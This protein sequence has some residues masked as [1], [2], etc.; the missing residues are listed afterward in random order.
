MLSSLYQQKH[1]DSDSESIFGLRLPI[2]VQQT[3]SA[4]SPSDGA[5]GVSA[6]RSMP[7][8]FSSRP[9]GDYDEVGEFEDSSFYRN[10]SRGHK[11]ECFLEALK[12]LKPIASLVIVIFEI[13]TLIGL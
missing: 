9:L 11:L 4:T 12:Y 3:S 8:A 7:C 2:F 5:E 6:M 1:S 13:Y 10:E